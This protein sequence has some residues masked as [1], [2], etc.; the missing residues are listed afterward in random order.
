MEELQYSINIIYNLLINANW[1]DDFRKTQG[2]VVIEELYLTMLKSMEP[3]SE[4]IKL[5]LSKIMLKVLDH[6]V[7]SQDKKGK[8]VG[9]GK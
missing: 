2:N 5:I 9:D 3:L 6:S 7:S 8:V 1:M 4:K